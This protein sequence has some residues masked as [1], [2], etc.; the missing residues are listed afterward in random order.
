MLDENE[1]KK[2]EIILKLEQGIITRKEASV[3]LKITLRQVDRLRATLKKE[4]KEGFIHKNKGKINA[5][6]IDRKIIEELENLY[7]EEYYDYN[8]VAF[9][10][11]LQE[12][13]SDKYNISYDVLLKQFK[14]DDIISP[15][16]HKKTIKLYT[17]NMN[18][19]IKK[20]EEILE[21]K[22]ELFISRQISFE[23]AHTRKANNLYTF[24]EEIQMDASEGYW[25]GDVITFLHL[26]VDKATK[27]VLFGWFEYEELS[28]AYFI[29]LYNIIINYG[30]PNRIKTD[31]RNSFSNQKK[32]VHTT[33]F[34]IICNILDIELI[35][36]SIPT[37]KANVERENKTFKG[38][39]IGVLRRNNIKDIDSANKFLN[40][41]FIPKMNKKF[42][43]EIIQENSKMKT[44]HYTEDE[45]NLII[46]EKHNR[47]IDNASS[48]KYKNKY[49]VPVNPVSGEIV[50][51][52]KKTMCKFIIS[53]N[54]E[55]WCEIE[56][57]YYKLLELENRD[58]IMKKEINNNKPIEKIKYIPPSSHPWRKSYKNMPCG[59]I[60]NN[61]V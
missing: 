51:F 9:Y 28:R 6:K 57:N 42:S 50:C 47:I 12:C 56:N 17:E 35:T 16:A 19:A 41:T 26:A 54:N 37:A 48:I 30:I 27:K 52:M 23:K 38:R 11:E 31:N 22:E 14:R 43:Y 20:K 15:L 25:F 5:N 59:S 32:E 60:A 44:N 46:S 4:G 53:Y 21:K 8:F 18:K 3:D 55:F 13:Y 40:E 61:R 45:L 10:E 39:L 1:Q 24:G 49:Y 34:G 29:M 58:S 36:T 33:Q 2:Y 7:L